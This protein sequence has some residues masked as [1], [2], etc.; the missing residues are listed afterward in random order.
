[1]MRDGRNKKR[2]LKSFHKTAVIL[3]KYIDSKPGIRYRQLLRKTNLAN[4][5][6]SCR[7]GILEKSKNIKIDRS[8]YDRTSYY[9]TYV[10]K[11]DWR[12]I[13]CISNSTTIQIIQFL[14]NR[15]YPPRF[16][17][18]VGH[19]KRAP[20]TISYHLKRLTKARIVSVDQNRLYGYRLI[21]KARILRILSQYEY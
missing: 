20:S 6:L 8:R 19:A 10:N 4:G 9:P 2:K 7:L 21:N 12:V 16:K 11:R 13:E 14:M 17:E 3:L 1:M 18:I 5:V 15:E